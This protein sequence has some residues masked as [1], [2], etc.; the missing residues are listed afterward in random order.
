[1]LSQ[2]DRKKDFQI[3]LHITKEV[4]NFDSNITVFLKLH[5]NTLTCAI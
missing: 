3:D 2:R 4:D 1:M 5:K